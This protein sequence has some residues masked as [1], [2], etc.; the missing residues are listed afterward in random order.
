MADKI[1][2]G[3]L[4]FS[5]LGSMLLFPDTVGVAV[6]E[7]KPE[8]FTVDAA[9]ALFLAIR[10][11][12][13]DGA[14]VNELSLAA[15]D[16]GCGPAINKAWE[17][18]GKSDSI[19]FYIGQLREASRLAAMQQAAFAIV[20]AEDLS[21]AEHL[22]DK[23]HAL[24][25]DRRGAEI[26]SIGDAAKAYMDA[27]RRK[28]RPRFIKTGLRI[29]DDEVFLRKG[30]FVVVGGFA[31]SGKTALT[32]QIARYMSRGLRVGY[33]SL[34]TD[35]QDIAI[36]NL[37]NLSGVG[38]KKVLQHDLSAADLAALE[39]AE[40]ELQHAQVEIIRTS[41]MSVSDIRAVTLSRRYDVIFVDHMQIIRSHAA[42]LYEQ[43][44]AISHEL[45]E[46]AQQ[47]DVLVVALSQLSRPE[48]TK[49]GKQLPPTMSNL[50]ESGH[51]EQDADVV[52]LIYPEDPA[53]YRSNRILKVSK[54]KDGE[55]LALSLKF[56]GWTQRFS[57]IGRCRGRDAQPAKLKQVADDGSGFILLPDNDQQKIPF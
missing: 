40:H 15:V 39:Q 32:L 28:E 43:I 9:R 49:G 35:S 11:L 56:E 8:D 53:D 34:E 3:D 16:P 23:L 10:Q 51:I 7:L 20:S 13:F 12:H 21:S 17:A 31:S 4:Q 38:N 22:L 37:V 14:P 2:L 33:F 54:N 18:P 6:A 52:A 47:H 50:R 19:D 25:C 42:S 5:I 24:A 26:V 41:G 29:F 27:V 48:T 45:H 44:T 1:T 57:V 55:K 36:R 30:K 46:L